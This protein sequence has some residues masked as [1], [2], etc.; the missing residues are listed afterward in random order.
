MITAFTL[1]TS[2]NATWKTWADGNVAMYS[3]GAKSIKTQLTTSYSGGS[4]RVRWGDLGAVKLVNVSMPS[5][6]VGCNGY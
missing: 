4:I 1:T 2:A 3:S 5:F 6:D